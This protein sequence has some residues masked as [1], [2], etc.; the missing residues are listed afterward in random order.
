MFD[1]PENPTQPHLAGLAPRADVRLVAIDLDGTLLR[2]DK[3][4]TVANADVIRAARDAGVRVVLATARPPRSTKEIYEAIGLDTLS[5]HYNGALIRDPV[6]GR[7][8]LHKPVDSAL[9]SAV[10]ATARRAYRKCVVSV[11]ILDKWYTDHYDDS[12]PIETGRAFTPDFVGPLDAFLTRPVTKLMLLAPPNR[13][14]SIK[15]AVLRKHGGSIGMAQSDHHLVQV[16]APNA[17]K[18]RAL[19]W[20][21]EHYGIPQSATMAIGDAPNDV[22]MIQWAGLGVA[23]ANAWQSV[24][25]VADVVTATNDEDGVAQAIRRYV[26]G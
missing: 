19:K 16:H 9:A 14:A 5:I 13:M 8:L 4:M 1:A 24:L 11:E 2:S 20:V 25:D 22:T 23:V 26:L 21:A 18:G 6:S 7:N 3:A 15:T 10:I 17:G 12:L